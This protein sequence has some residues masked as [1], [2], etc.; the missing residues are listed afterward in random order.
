[1]GEHHIRSI[2]YLVTPEK[3]STDSANQPHMLSSWTIR[4]CATCEASE[5]VEDTVKKKTECTHGSML[6]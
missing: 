3:V 1:M 6:F 4:T 5:A 2:G